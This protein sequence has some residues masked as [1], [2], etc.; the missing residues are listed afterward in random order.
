MGFKLAIVW[1]VRY[2]AP[3]VITFIVIDFWLL[4]SFSKKINAI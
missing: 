3:N 4:E 1:E 2:R